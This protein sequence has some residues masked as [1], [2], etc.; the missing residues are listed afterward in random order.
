MS[1]EKVCAHLEKEFCRRKHKLICDCCALQDADKQTCKACRYCT[2]FQRCLNENLDTGNLRWRKGSL[3]GGDLEI[4][5]VMFNLH[6]KRLPLEILK[7]KADDYVE[8][9]LL[10]SEK[11]RNMLSVIEQERSCVR[12][13]NE[14]SDDEAPTQRD[15]MST[16]LSHAEMAAE[17]HRREQLLK[18]G[19]NSGVTDQWRVYT[20]IVNPLRLATPIAPDGAGQ[21]GHR[22]YPSLLYNP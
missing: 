11:A 14:V 6:R 9:G 7:R 16:R 3:Q 18:A 15:T 21:R 8:E 19:G 12:T 4:Q 1:F 20:H 10:S 22:S 2:G 13:I 17:L 5:R